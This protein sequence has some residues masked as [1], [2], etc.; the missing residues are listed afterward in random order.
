MCGTHMLSRWLLGSS[1]GEAKWQTMVMVHVGAWWQCAD[2]KE[3]GIPQAVESPA[4][5]SEQPASKGKTHPESCTD[6]IGRLLMD[7]PSPKRCAWSL[8]HFLS[9]QVEDPRNGFL[10]SNTNWAQYQFARAA[11]LKS[12][13]ATPSMP[14]RTPRGVRPGVRRVFARRTPRAYA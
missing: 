8:L 6:R 14:A 4:P 3:S 2:P 13:R 7:R 12:R 10:A 5:A 11:T 1:A 9:G